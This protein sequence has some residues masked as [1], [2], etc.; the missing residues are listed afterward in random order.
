MLNRGNCSKVLWQRMTVKIG[1]N[2]R[3]G[4]IGS[5]NKI[6]PH[7]LGTWKQVKHSSM[8][9]GGKNRRCS[10]E[11][12]FYT[13]HQMPFIPPIFLFLITLGYEVGRVWNLGLFFFLLCLFWKRLF[14]E[15][16]ADFAESSESRAKQAHSQR[17]AVIPLASEQEHGACTQNQELSNKDWWE[18][19]WP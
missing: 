18:C 13:H 7:L 2:N 15:P 10:S 16:L 12:A 14:A 1:S 17:D 11:T 4:R 6:V 19:V 9:A 3:E 8:G 5:R